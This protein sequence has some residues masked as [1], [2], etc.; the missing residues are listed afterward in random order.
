MGKASSI[1]AARRRVL[2]NLW[3]KAKIIVPA[4]LL[5]VAGFVVAFQFVEPAPP[6]RIVLASGA[7]NGAYHAFAQRYVGRFAE[8]GVEL[9]IRPTAGSEENVRLL[10][11]SSSGV[12][13]AFVQGGIGSPADHPGLVSL[14][15]AYYEPLWVFVRRAAPLRWLNELKGARIAV[16]VPGSG[17]RPVAL[18]LLADNGVTA[19]TATLLDIGGTDA[20]DALTAGRIDAALFISGARAPLITRLLDAPGIRLVSFGRADAYTRLH[21]YLSPVTLPEGVIDLA[22]NLPP[23]EIRLLA[24]AATLVANET[25]H[26]ALASLLLDAMSDTHSAGGLLEQPGEFPSARYV[27]FP[28]ADQARRYYE[29]GPPLLQ[30]FLPFWA[31]NLIDRLKIMILPLVTLMYPLFKLLMPTYRWRMGAKINRNYKALQRLDDRIVAGEISDN[32]AVMELNRIENQV[33]R[34]SIPA[35]YA[36]R[37]YHLRLHIDL[38]RRRLEVQKETAPAA[39]VAPGPTPVGVAAA[40]PMA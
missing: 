7:E 10:A 29:G 15:S 14:G 27:T 28:L 8:E 11:D 21:R 22:R 23:R 12:S 2:I 20:A 39:P 26:P 16:G 3:D 30:R 40:P 18:R 38:L 5:V 32:D 33:L 31:A 35:G 17:T 4:I 1:W 37:V 6:R 34:L 13:V 24:P 25:L 19:Q 36:E 9:V